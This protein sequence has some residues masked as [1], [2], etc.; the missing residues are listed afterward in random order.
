MP[1]RIIREGILD[2]RAINSLSDQGEIFYRRLMSIV[3][4]YGRYEAEPD[5]IRARCFARSLD[6]WPLSRVSA[7]LSEVSTVLTDDGHPLVIV[8]QINGRKYLEISKFEQRLRLKRERCPPPVSQA[9]VACQAN[10]GH[11]SDICRLESESESESESEENPNPKAIVRAIPPSKSVIVLQHASGL[12][13]AK[14]AHKRYPL[15]EWANSLYD[16]HPKKKDLPLVQLALMTALD[17]ADFPSE[18]YAEIA[19]VHGLWCATFQWKQESGRYCPPLAKWIADR[20]WTAEP[21]PN[22]SKEEHD[23]DEYDRRNGKS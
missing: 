8:Y 19:R 3:D 14:P 20:G 22:I 2:S 15:E 9:P 10:D 13:L 4:D 5:L 12:P 23:L 21:Q 6:R 7:A 1:N 11:A 18:A 16:L 17:C